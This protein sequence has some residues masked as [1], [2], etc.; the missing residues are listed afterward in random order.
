MHLDP[1]HERMSELHKAEVLKCYTGAIGNGSFLKGVAYT[2]KETGNDL[3][4]ITEQTNRLA[5]LLDELEM[6][7]SGSKKKLLLDKLSCFHEKT[8]TV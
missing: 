1:L 7:K 3:K 2:N 8:P 5:N 6:K 4:E